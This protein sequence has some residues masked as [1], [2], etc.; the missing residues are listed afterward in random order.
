MGWGCYPSVIYYLWERGILSRFGE[1]GGGK[2]GFSM[3]TMLRAYMYIPSSQAKISLHSSS[4]DYICKQWNRK[5]CL[6]TT[7]S[8]M[9]N[10]PPSLSFFSLVKLKVI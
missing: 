7:C 5:T 2:L 10:T 3:K 4:E 6:Q 8:Q 9:F 1:G